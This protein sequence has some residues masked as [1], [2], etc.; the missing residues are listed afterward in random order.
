MPTPIKL[1]RYTGSAYEV[2]QPETTWSQVTD[3]PSTFT[4]TAHTHVVADITNNSTL[5]KTTGNQS[6]AGTKTFTDGVFFNS[7]INSDGGTIQVNVDSL[8]VDG[9]I[10]AGDPITTTRFVSTQTTGTAPLTVASTTAVANLNAD[11]LDGNHSSAFA[12]ASHNHDAGNITTGT[13]AVGRGGTGTTSM[14]NGGIPFGNQ[15]ATG[16]SYSAAPSLQNQVLRSTGY[17]GVNW[18]PGWETPA[19]STSASAIGTSSALATARDIYYGTP[20]INNSKSYTSSTTI[21]APTAGGLANYG[22]FGNGTTSAPIWVRPYTTILAGVSMSNN[23]YSG[24]TVSIANYR[25][26]KIQ[27]F[28]TASSTTKRNEIII[29][30]ADT[31][32]LGSSTGNTTFWRM[33]W[34]DGSSSWADT[35]T[36]RRA[37][38]TTM[39]FLINSGVLWTARVIGFRGAA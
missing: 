27:F 37:S 29:D 36:I 8:N 20:T 16:F 32:Q 18:T 2:L 19:D 10:S 34:N 33:Q 39:T 14:T 11:L 1:K 12:P 31:K 35:V 6:I 24:T 15:G 9:G 5:V 38:S 26:I 30:T 25:F 3:K 17:N 22:L 23:S 7:S 13:L 4:P 28:I 21:Y